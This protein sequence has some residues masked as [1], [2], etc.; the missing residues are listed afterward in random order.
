MYDFSLC[1]P[2]WVADPD[3]F[4]AEVANIVIKEEIPFLKGTFGLLFILAVKYFIWPPIKYWWRE[5][6]HNGKLQLK[7][8]RPTC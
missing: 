4:A 5:H 2:K 8:R 1:D 6:V 7:A 3:E